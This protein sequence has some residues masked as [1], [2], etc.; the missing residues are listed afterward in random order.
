MQRTIG[1][2]SRLL[3]IFVIL[4]WLFSLLFDNFNA[5]SCSC[6]E[7]TK[8]WSTGINVRQDHNMMQNMSTVKNRLM[9]WSKEFKN[10][11]K[12]IMDILILFYIGTHT[13]STHTFLSFSKAFKISTFMNFFSWD[14]SNKIIISFLCFRAL[15]DFPIRNKSVVIMGS[16]VCLFLTHS[17]TH[18][19]I[20]SF[21]HSLT[22][23]SCCF[24]FFRLWYN[25]TPH[26][27]YNIV[28]RDQFM[29]ACVWFLE[30]LN[31]KQLTFNQL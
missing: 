25:T 9:N 2:Y 17:L 31:A 12:I 24:L 30:V 22:F 8:E 1:S 10:V 16:Q 6:F 7:R 18:S 20:H 27:L 14:M 11:K 3:L 5:D 23:I 13:T 4:L 15:D 28:Y 19:L 29:K 21:I 26:C